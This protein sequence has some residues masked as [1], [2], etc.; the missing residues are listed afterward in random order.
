MTATDP[1]EIWLTALQ[2]RHLADLTMPEVRRALQALSYLY[3]EDRSRIPRGGAFNS[4]G[5]RTAFALFYAPLHFLQVRCVIRALGAADPAPHQI[6]DLGCG[7]GAAG[8]AWALETA[9]RSLVVGVDRHPWA[10]QETRW[11]YATLNLR[12][13]TRRARLDQI[14]FGAGD[15]VIAAFT[16]NELEPPVRSNMLGRLMAAARRGGALLIVE[17]ISRRVVPWWEEWAQALRPLQARVDEWRFEQPLPEPLQRLDTAAGLDHS[18]LT[19]RSLWVAQ[20]QTTD[21]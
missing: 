19:C 4:R 10:I 8:A 15:S 14:P 7:T 21:D 20:I 5:K 2:Q 11:T 1:F 12:G 9:G 17:P 3:V 13:R 16:V 18:V 6:L